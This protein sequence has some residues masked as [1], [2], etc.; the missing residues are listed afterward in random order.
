M[1]TLHKGIG[2]WKRALPTNVQSKTVTEGM[3]ESC[4]VGSARPP[5]LLVIQTLMGQE[6]EDRRVDHVLMW[7]L[8]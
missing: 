6:V 1:K 7:N 5:S 2:L 4:L 8:V 3:I